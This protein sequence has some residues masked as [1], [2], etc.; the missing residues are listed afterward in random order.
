MVGQ[1]RLGSRYWLVVKI[2]PQGNELWSDTVD[3]SSTDS[4]AMCV[5]TETNDN[6]FVGGTLKYGAGTTRESTIR[7][8]DKDGNLQ[9]QRI[10]DAN[11]STSQHETITEVVYEAQTNSVYS[12][13]NARGIFVG[14]TNLNNGVSTYAGIR[15]NSS[16]TNMAATGMVFDHSALRA[17]GIGHASS[18]SNSSRQYDL[19]KV[20]TSMQTEYRQV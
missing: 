6:V 3:G 10:V 17:Y 16:N 15:E 8:Y 4:T 13:G 7:M 11:T 1:S 2:D 14:R 5:T 9:W 18:L 19:A 12:F 20:T